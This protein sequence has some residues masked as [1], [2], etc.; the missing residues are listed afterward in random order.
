M[1]GGV[2]DQPALAPIAAIQSVLDQTNTTAKT[3][4]SVEIMEAYAAQ[5]IIAAQSQPFD[6]STINKGGGA[7][8]RG[9]PIGASGAILAVRLYHELQKSGG[10]GLATIAAA[11]GLGSALL[12]QA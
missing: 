8:S 6:P 1:L 11:G 5:A 10:T 7:L 2:P 3:L 12:L 9:H 4:T